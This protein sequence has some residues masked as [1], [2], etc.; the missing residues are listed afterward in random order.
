MKESYFDIDYS[1]Y[2]ESKCYGLISDYDSQEKCLKGIII[3]NEGS[4]YFERSLIDLAHFI[5]TKIKMKSQFC[6]MIKF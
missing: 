3:E 1:M 4:P 6:I 2:Q 5:R